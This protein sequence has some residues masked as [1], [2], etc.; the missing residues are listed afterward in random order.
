MI[1]FSS[2]KGVIYQRKFWEFV[3]QIKSFRGPYVVHACNRQ[4]PNTWNLLTFQVS[5]WLTDSGIDSFKNLFI[6][7][8]INGSALLNF[9]SGSGLKDLGVKNKEDREKIKKKIKELITQNAKDKKET[10]K[11][12]KLL[13][14]VV[15]RKKWWKRRGQ[16]VP[17]TSIEK[18]LKM[19]YFVIFRTMNF[20]PRI[21]WNSSSWIAIFTYKYLLYCVTVSK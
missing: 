8:S 6:D 3:G 10:G 7:K 19:F 21:K 11:T 4:S 9:E 2:L 13:K 18:F 5:Q 16:N 15:V 20:G 1:S 12:E 14:K 17:E